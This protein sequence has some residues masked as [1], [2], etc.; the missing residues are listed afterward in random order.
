MEDKMENMDIL[1][2]MV[3]FSIICCVLWHNE[4]PIDMFF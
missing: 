3:D 1:F 2:G 4:R